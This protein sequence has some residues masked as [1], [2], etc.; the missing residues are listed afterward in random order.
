MNTENE[1]APDNQNSHMI[2]ARL[3][4]R[5][6]IIMAMLITVVS[7]FAMLNITPEVFQNGWPQVVQAGFI[8]LSKI[9]I[10]GL[11]IW[12]ITRIGSDER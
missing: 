9:G 8:L 12:G 2:R 3:R 4:F 11:C 5:F 10:L 6:R 7:C 1:T